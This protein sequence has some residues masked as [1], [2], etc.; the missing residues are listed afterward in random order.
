VAFLKPVQD[1]DYGEAS[2]RVLEQQAE[3]FDRVYG[4]CA[5]SVYTLNAL[6]GTGSLDE[7]KRFVVGA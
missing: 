2:I 3:N 6:K 4:A 5:D 7:L 1:S